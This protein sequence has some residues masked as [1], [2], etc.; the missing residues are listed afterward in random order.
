MSKGKIRLL[1]KCLGKPIKSKQ[2]IYKR[3]D[4]LINKRELGA[5][6]GD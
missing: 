1:D 5:N 3:K 6:K 4:H 2:L